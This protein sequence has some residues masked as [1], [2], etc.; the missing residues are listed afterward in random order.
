MPAYISHAIMGSEVYKNSQECGK[1]FQTSVDENEFRAYSLG[2]DLST[3]SKKNQKDPHNY[4][5]QAFFLNMINYIKE[6]KLIENGHILALLY[7]HMSHYFFDINSH[8]LVYYNER[9][10]EKIGMISNH[11][12]VEG[13][14][15]SYLAQ[16]VLDKDI[17]E[18]KADYF[19]QVDLSLREVINLLN[20][21]YGKVYGDSTIVDTY[22]KTFLIFKTLETAIK[23][24]LISK[25]MLIAISKFN[26]FLDRNKLSI[27][28]LT[29]E[30]KQTYT[31]P[32]TGEKH[33]DSFMELY[34]KSIDMTLD[35]LIKVNG[36]L[37]DNSTLFSLEKVFTD[38]SY[39]T[40]VSCSLG[41]KLV[42][43]RGK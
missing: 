35:A 31:N 30:N 24:G 5:T 13:Y 34:N 18:V 26:E 21:V 36:Y 28:D 1:V 19:S 20:S 37:Y 39:D 23:S 22:K 9:G 6:N 12:L 14:L 11:N 43:V 3:L 27:S 41:K 40:G 7:G 32:V 8:P 10:C 2:A 33:N 4:Y 15:N 38:L 16:K 17:M 25:N 42:Y 29:N